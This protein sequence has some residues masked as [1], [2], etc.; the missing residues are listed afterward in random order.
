[1]SGAAPSTAS[2]SPSPVRFAPGEDHGSLYVGEVVHQR[3]ANFEHRL[4]YGLY[5][6][7]LDIDAIEATTR[8]L[9]LLSHGRFG[10]M[11][12]SAR[13]HGD[14]SD[15]PLRA[16]IET[17]LSAAGIDL[18]GGVIRLLTMPRILGYG[19]N[20][21]SVYFCHSPDGSIAAL[22]YE[23]TNTF[24]E[25]H[26]YVVALPEDQPSGPIRQ[27]TEKRFFVSPYMDMALTYDF[28]VQPP[29]EAVSVV[30]AVRRGDTPILTA[31]FAG[32]RRPLTDA[33]LLR[34]FVTHPLLTW[35]V[36]AGIHW[37]ALKM[38]LKGARYRDRPA[39]PEPLTVG[40]PHTS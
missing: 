23:V 14:R 3:V 26:S 15:T 17:H 2:R 21:I 20:P 33:E 4:S 27:T 36:T 39:P 34:A 29:G 10:L 40:S 19:F 11:S 5:M 16:Q 35:K 25:R 8:R 13:D 24:H 31:S 28:T 32:H 37:E 22:V 18:R 38:M 1:M 30:V 12:V 7:L 6:L 9:R